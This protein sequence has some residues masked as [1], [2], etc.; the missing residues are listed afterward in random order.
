MYAG[1]RIK[2]ES[3]SMRNEKA[4]RN[5]KMSWQNFFEEIT[6]YEEWHL[7]MYPQEYRLG[8]RLNELKYV[9]SNDNKRVGEYYLDETERILKARLGV[10]TKDDFILFVKLRDEHMKINADLK[11]NVF[12]V[13]HSLTDNVV[14]LFGLEQDV[15]VSLFERF[16]D[17]EENVSNIVAS[18]GGR[19]LTYEETVYVNRYHYI[20][21][22]K[23]D[24]VDEKLNGSVE[25]ITNTII[26]PTETSVLKLD[27]D[28]DEGYTAILVVDDFMHNM[29]ESNLFY[30]VQ[31]M[32][33]PVEIQIKAKA[34]KKSTTKMKLNLKQKELKESSME[35]AKTG[36]R[37]D[38]SVSESHYLVRNLQDDIKKSDVSLINW[39][40][41]I[42]VYGK[43]KKEVLNR[44][45]EVKRHLKNWEIKC[46]VP[47]ADQLSLFY[48]MLPGE[49]LDTTTTNWLQKTTQD[50]LAECMFGVNTEVGSK[51]GFF[52][53]W[54]DRF[55]KHVNLER[56]KLSS[57][58]PVLFHPFLANENISGSKTRSPHVLITGD[59]GNGKSYL[60]KVIFSYI[61]LMNVRS[62]YIDPKKEY[63]KWINKVIND[64]VVNR[65]FPL[66]V[67]HLKQFKF[68]TLDYEDE[69]NWGAL[70]PVVFMPPK[71]AKDLIEDIFLQVYD[72]KG[73]DEV[74]TV[75]LQAIN[76]VLEARQRGESV[77]SMHIIDMMQH[78]EE[79]S[80]QKAG[81]FLNEVIVNSVLK[82][83]IHDGSHEGLNLDNRV[84]VIEV[85]N[86]D[87][88]EAK[89]DYETYTS[90]Q[91]KSNAIMLALGKYCELFGKQDKE[92]KT[93]EFI[94]EAW[95]ITSSQQGKKVEKSM[96]RVGRSYN[97]ALYFISQS[98]KDALRE[99]ENETNNFG[100]AFAFD[101]P[102]E[103]ESI[104]K[105]MN[106]EVT[107]ENQKMF[108]DMLQ[109]QCLFKDIYG[110][111]SKIT[112]DCLF[113]EWEGALETITK[114][115]V[116]YA[117]EKYL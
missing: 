63:R 70:D 16:Q 71:Q 116:A 72:F 19:K 29:A 105:W 10:M 7:M 8:E 37:I 54:V 84:S 89:D 65:D 85:E 1:Y 81:D 43:T 92:E 47:V 74:Y 49:R 113:E 100:V 104:L 91:L 41:T 57:R 42:F 111:T 21:G 90:S 69:R 75:F 34:E 39:I 23:H 99:E 82:L 93:V 86:L 107:E 48:K 17:E 62:L 79:S 31:S 109:G 51:I 14:R 102:S 59:T 26:D 12:R 114:S 61:T 24:I 27:N 64:S 55:S 9:L 40:A 44:A 76:E 22:L 5:Y 46:H 66:Y 45:K 32:P 60:A 115:S 13:F 68:I 6:S 97:N 95:M 18:V 87:L 83:C 80:V 108:E 3:I 20:R 52:I 11:D 98:T 25:S 58:D 88:P 77:G 73:K 35:Q 96:R 106:M 36:D 28:E 53:G 78:S 103:R 33:F 15:P 67:E 4:V 101:E 112:I 38:S 2:S 110:R 94:D 117:E 30:R 50:G 56:A